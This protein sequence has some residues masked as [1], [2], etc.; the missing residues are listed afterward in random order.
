MVE[1]DRGAIRPTWLQWRELRMGTETGHAS[2]VASGGAGVGMQV[3]MA[4]RTRAIEDQGE[5]VDA[6]MLV[7]AAHA[8]RCISGY[9]P[10]M[11]SESL[12]AADTGPVHDQ[13][14]AILIT[15]NETAEWLPWSDVTILAVESLVDRGDWAGCMDPML[16]QPNIIGH[17]TEREDQSDGEGDRRTM[18]GD[19]GDDAPDDASQALDSRPCGHETSWTVVSCDRVLITHPMGR[20]RRMATHGRPKGR[21]QK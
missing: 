5:R 4:C 10:A 13:V 16:T 18:G 21:R 1:P 2:G 8:S 9:L 15:S 11:R 17:P 7:V 6:S 3:G 19:R 14:G 12:V 20:E